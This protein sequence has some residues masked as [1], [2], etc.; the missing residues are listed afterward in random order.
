MKIVFASLEKIDFRNTFENISVIESV[1]QLE[2]SAN[3]DT[4]YVLA[5]IGG[6]VESGGR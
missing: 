5:A 3:E 6:T 1:E 2:N 4:T